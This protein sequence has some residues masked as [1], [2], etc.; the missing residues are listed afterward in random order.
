MKI[1][2][3]MLI[4]ILLLYIIYKV[5]EKV[6]LDISYK[7]RTAYARRRIEYIDESIQSYESLMALARD[8]YVIKKYQEMISALQNEK[9]ELLNKLK[10][11]EQQ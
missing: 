10:N 9:T 7:E 4:G 6:L 5:I 11:K 2:L 3:I 8:S 1:L